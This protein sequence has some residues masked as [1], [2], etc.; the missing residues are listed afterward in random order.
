MP[1]SATAR[2][3]HHP[4]RLFVLAAACGATVGATAA[5]QIAS[6]RGPPTPEP[7]MPASASPPNSSGYEAADTR[8]PHASAAAQPATTPSTISALE[9]TKPAPPEPQGAKASGT[10]SS[11]A[12]ASPADQVPATATTAAPAEAGA[13]RQVTWGTSVERQEDERL[14]VRIQGSS[15]L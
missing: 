6:D 12:S 1:C 5:W 8:S 13:Y 3:M 9:S 10:S 2:D 7:R 11:A 14:C 15:G 4:P